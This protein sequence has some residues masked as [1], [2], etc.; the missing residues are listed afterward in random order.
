MMQDGDYEATVLDALTRAVA[1]ALERKHLL[2]QYAVF[3]REGRVVCV[4]PDAPPLRYRS[5][6]ESERT[7]RGVA[8]PG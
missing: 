1:E 7:L 3:W 4:G 8:E 2:G 5:G 6:A